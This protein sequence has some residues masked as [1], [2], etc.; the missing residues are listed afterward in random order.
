MRKLIFAL[1]FLAV[2]TELRAQEAVYDTGGLVLGAALNGVAV[3][4]EDEE[5]LES[6]G[7]LTLQGGYGF[8]P[9]T[10]FLRLGGDAV[11]GASGGGDYSLAHV[12][13]GGRYHLGGTSRWQPFLEAAY[14]GRAVTFDAIDLD[15]RGAGITLGGGL[16]YFIAPAFSLGATLDYTFGDFEEARVSEGE[17][18][19]LGSDA[20]SVTTTR[21][22]LG[23]NWHP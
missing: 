1:A 19:D 9:L 8:G 3:Q 18:V 23:V 17:W 13:L 12:D 10:V 4:T 15:A 2:P 7:G 14:S 21:V 16:F 20:F 22:D 11:T 5:E 6:G